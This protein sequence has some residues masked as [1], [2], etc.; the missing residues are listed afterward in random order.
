MRCPKLV[1]SSK[2]EANRR[3][4]QHSSGPRTGR[5]ERNSRFN[6]VTLGLF[7]KHVVIPICD[8][9]RPEKEF[10]IL[11]DGLHQDFHPVG[12]YEEWLVVKVAESDECRTSLEPVGWVRSEPRESCHHS[13]RTENADMRSYKSRPYRLPGSRKALALKRRK[14][15]DLRRFW[16]R[17][18]RKRRKPWSGAR[19]GDSRGLTSWL[20]QQSREERRKYRG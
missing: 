17:P 4:S 5:G 1:T 10:Q 3:N 8:G 7:A 16:N 9:F 14:D 12:L 2:V 20:H 6:A 13:S 11:L 15:K 19:G 18:Q